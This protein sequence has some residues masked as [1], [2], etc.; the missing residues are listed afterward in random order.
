[1]AEFFVRNSLNPYKTVKLG[2]TFRQMVLKGTGG[3]LIWLVEVKTDEPDVDG[4]AIT[5]EY[6][7]LTS[8]N[9][10]DQ[11]I[12][13]VA[14]VIAGKID[15]APLVDDTRPPYVIS[16]NPSEYLVD[17]DEDVIA[18]IK[19]S[20]PS[21][22]IDYDSIKITINGIDESSQ[23]TI[24]GDPYEYTIKWSPPVRLRQSI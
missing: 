10:L 11:E 1:M 20:L 3:E 12:Q 5:P 6:V 13:K 23:L 21:A 15:W 4:N 18:T 16:V 9:N 8:L 19:E 2:V 22:G 14:S 7:H 17:I 24:I